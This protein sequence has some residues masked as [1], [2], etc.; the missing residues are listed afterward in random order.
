MSAHICWRKR[1][2]ALFTHKLFEGHFTKAR[3]LRDEPIEFNFPMVWKARIVG[4]FDV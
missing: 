1:V 4:L 2:L 3:Y